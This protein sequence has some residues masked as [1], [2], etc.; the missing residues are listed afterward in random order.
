M[1]ERRVSLTSPNFHTLHPL[2]FGRLQGR[3]VHLA[4]DLNPTVVDAFRAFGISKTDARGVTFATH[5]VGVYG[6]VVVEIA[7]PNLEIV[8]YRGTRA[9]RD[10]YLV[11][12]LNPEPLYDLLLGV[13]TV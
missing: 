2:K 11:D 4:P 12:T 9:V 8:G 3:Q 6:R 1:L 7:A 13:L 10:W 5:G